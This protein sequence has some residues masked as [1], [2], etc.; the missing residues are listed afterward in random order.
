M[1]LEC[2]VLPA[3]GNDYSLVVLQL[4]LPPCFKYG[5]IQWL[6]KGKRKAITHPNKTHISTIETTT[7]NIHTYNIRTITK[8]YDSPIRTRVVSCADC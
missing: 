4:R 8:N 1:Q 7:T 5:G 3:Q 6:H 2:V